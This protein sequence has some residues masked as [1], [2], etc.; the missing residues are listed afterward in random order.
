MLRAKPDAGCWTVPGG[1]VEPGETL[2]DDGTNDAV[3]SDD[4]ADVGWFGRER[5]ELHAPLLMTCSSVAGL[6]AQANG[7]ARPVASQRLRSAEAPADQPH[8]QN[9][10]LRP[11]GAYTTLEIT[12]FGSPLTGNTRPASKQG[13]DRPGL[14]VSSEFHLNLTGRAL[15]TVLPLTSVQRP[16]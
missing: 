1:R 3:A 14:V 15:V 13:K 8:G 6:I 5:T 4:A 7:R 2:E 12:E 9:H 16:G 11:E 10:L